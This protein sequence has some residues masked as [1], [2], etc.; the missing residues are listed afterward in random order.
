MEE[1]S[2][3]RYNDEHFDEWNNFVD[4]SRNAT[5]LIN[6]NYLDYHKARFC[7]ASVMI[8][9]SGKLKAL[10]PAN[11]DK[12]SGTIWSHQGLTYGGIVTHNDMTGAEMLDIFKILCT[13]FK[14]QYN[15]TQWIYK[16]YPHI[17]ASNPSEEDLYALFKVGAQLAVRQISCTISQDNKLPFRTLRKRGMKKAMLSNYEVKDDDFEGLKD[18]WTVLDEVLT[19]CHGTHPVHSYEEL[20][21]L[22]SRF[23]KNIILHTVANPEGKICAGVLVFLS[24]MVAHAQYIAA[25][26]EAKHNGALD[27]LFYHLI[28]EVYPDVPYFDF[29]ISTEQGGKILNEGLLFQKEGFGGRA[30]CYDMYKINL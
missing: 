27:L 13:Y 18:Y 6:R 10:V 24:K 15:A 19:N 3:V 1:I 5:F 9:I 21:L 14:E 26:D 20:S 17:Y 12:S 11:F 23:R 7:D 29:G 16:P 22:S 4:S 25:N 30:V 8:Y 2:I 28:N